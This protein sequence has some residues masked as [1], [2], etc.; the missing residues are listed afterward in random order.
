MVEFTSTFLNKVRNC[1]SLIIRHL[2]DIAE[3]IENNLNDL[4][5][6]HGQ[7]VAEWRDHLFLNQVCHLYARETM[8]NISNLTW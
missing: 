8:R 1:F 3:P 7:Q 4:G 5:V 2:E 6:L